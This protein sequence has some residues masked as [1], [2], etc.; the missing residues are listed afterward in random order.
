MPEAYLIRAGS[1]GHLGSLPR[2]RRHAPVNEG[3]RDDAN[4][5]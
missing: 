2:P 5:W 4:G 1:M 3:E